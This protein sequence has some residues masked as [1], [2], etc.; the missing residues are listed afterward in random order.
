MQRRA[1]VLLVGIVLGGTAGAARADEL[2]VGYTLE[3]ATHSSYVSR[4]DRMTTTSVEDVVQPAGELRLENIG[5]G[6]LIGGVWTSRGLTE[7]EA[8]QEI[9]RTWRTPRRSARSRCAAASRSTSCRR[10]ARSTTSTS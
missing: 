9:D 8:G 3:V 7:T 6:A 1:G 5:P 4:G 10:W 2:A